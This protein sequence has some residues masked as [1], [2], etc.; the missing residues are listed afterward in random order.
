MNYFE[1][2]DK[3]FQL[4]NYSI[5]QK[6]KEDILLPY[7]NYLN[8]HHMKNCF[9]YKKLFENLFLNNKLFDSNNLETIPFIPVQL[10]KDFDLMSIKNYEIFKTMSSSGTSGNK[11]SK[12][13]LNKENA[14]IQTRV[15]SKIISSF[16]GNKRVP[17]LI[18]DSSKSIKD[19]NTFSVRR[20]ATLGF[21]IFSK[22][23]P[24]IGK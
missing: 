1:S 13:F 4:E 24:S 18:V 2:L 12:I 11:L 16:L 20:A 6:E 8:Y 5:L 17:M 19:R 15:L 22:K 23:S 3:I 7:F 9:F 10:F 21:S 14:R